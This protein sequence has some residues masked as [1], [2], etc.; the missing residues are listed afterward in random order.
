MKECQVILVTGASR[1]IGKLTAL[2]LAKRGHKVYATM[3]NPASFKEHHKNFVVRYLDVN[4]I[5]SIQLVIEEMILK[6]KRVDV[7][8]NNA[9]YGL[10]SP[11]DAA[12]DEEIMR[13]FQV[14]LFG[15]IRVIREALP[16]MRRERKG[17][18]I[19]LSSIAGL[20]SNPGLG[21]YCAS[22]HAL[23]AMSASLASTVFP[24]NIEVVVVEPG[25]TDTEFADVLDLGGKKVDRSPVYGDF[26]EKY[27]QKLKNALAEGQPPQEVA[28]LI[29]NIVEESKP[30]FRYQTSKRGE[31]T[32]R[33]FI[34]DPTGDQWLNEQKRSL[35]EWLL[36]EV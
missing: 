35:K 32:A 20:V 14:N 13:Q 6:E 17:R 22:K 29:A 9:G 27:Q 3:R 10:L 30:H 7:V 11:V 34:I 23:E 33:Q 5:L 36:P 26:N 28:L 15:V 1:G 21:W 24:W 2:E 19:N 16:H 12:T 18:I 31:E 8:I 4:D 25:A